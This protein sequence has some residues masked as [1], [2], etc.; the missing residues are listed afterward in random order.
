MSPNST[1]NFWA[2]TSKTE[3]SAS[4]TPSSTAVRNSGRPAAESTKLNE[5]RISVRHIGARSPL[6][7]GKK[8]GT[9]SKLA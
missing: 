7:Y 9:D 5:P 8:I 2:A 4:E 6:M 1:S 3:R